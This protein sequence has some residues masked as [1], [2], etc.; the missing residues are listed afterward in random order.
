MN[1]NA[2]SEQP[3]TASRSKEQQEIIKWLHDIRFKKKLFGGVDEMDVWQKIEELNALYEKAL[4]AE[5]ARWEAG[6]N[7]ADE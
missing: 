5:R 1:Q 4:L 2:F 6:G 3:S 7:H